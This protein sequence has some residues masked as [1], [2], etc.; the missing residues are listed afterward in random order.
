[1]S[2]LL[3]DIGN[4]RIKWALARGGRIGPMRAAEHGRRGV[5]EQWL[6]R[7]RGIDAVEAASVA[8]PAARRQLQAALRRNDLPP[9]R[10]ARSTAQAAGV[11]NSYA[12]PW[13]LGVDRWMAAIGAWH[14]AGGRRAVC[15]ISV[16]TALTV[17]VVD[18]QGRHR[19]GLIAPA[20]ELMVRALLEQTH[21]I[22]VR[23]KRA[24]ARG[25]ASRPTPALSPLASTTQ[26]AIA[27]GSLLAAAALADR[28][29]SEVAR[30]LAARPRIFLTGG[31]AQ[32]I[33][34]LLRCRFDLLP[35]LVLR[36]LLAL[37]AQTH[38]GN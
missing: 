16:G 13:R 11:T 22:A 32:T 36:G 35:D 25:G 23:A 9:A 2:T 31:A 18:A 34:P 17:D 7:A 29:V 38:A 24:A 12:E 6:G 21:G 33:A 15:V 14:Q 37:T 20:P 3:I 4:T 26:N 28:C 10:F 19:G 27:Q 30:S 8:S 5:F 1:L